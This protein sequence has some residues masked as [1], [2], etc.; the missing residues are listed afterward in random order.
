MAVGMG[1]GGSVPCN[2]VRSDHEL[3][4]LPFTMQC[5]PMRKEA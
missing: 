1:I 5:H 3:L 4:V 2:E